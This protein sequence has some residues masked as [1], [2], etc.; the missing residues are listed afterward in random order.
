MAKPVIG[1]T[2]LYD[3]EQERLWMRPNYLRAVEEAGGVPLVL[4]L[5]GGEEDVAAL[6]GLCDGFLFTGGPD[7][8]PSLFGEET[9]R[10]CGPIDSRRDKFE[11]L[12]LNRAVKLDKP[13]LGICRGIQL[14]NAALGGSLY[15]DIPAQVRG[16]PVAH[17]QKPPYDVAVHSIVIEKESP[18]CAILHKTEMTVN[19]M[20]HQA[21]KDLA[22]P[23]R[24][25]ASSADG[26][27]ECVWMPG[28]RFFLGVQW[29]PEYLP[30][31][32]S[33]NLFRAFLS[34]AKG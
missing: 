16:L 23:L 27:A 11:I 28:K 12:L 9:L 7:V 26:L 4:P 6:S 29:H 24:C 18:L 25:A 8:H 21:I 33:G 1:L 32:E 22:P 30:G 31:P 14:M 17:N 15:Q 3:P 5:A 34:A 19:S 20:H 10:F 2:P 13:M